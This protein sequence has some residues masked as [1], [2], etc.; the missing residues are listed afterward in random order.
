MGVGTAMANDC[1]RGLLIRHVRSDVYNDNVEVKLPCRRC[2]ALK[3]ESE[4]HRSTIRGRQAW[5]K[6]CRKEYDASYWKKTRVER[7]QFRRLRQAELEGWHRHIKETTPCA[8]CGGQFHH[9]SMH[10]D[11]LRGKRNGSR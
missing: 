5:C 7:V 6:S 4:F 11:H 8:D 3:L 2:G 1:W 9:A 10:W